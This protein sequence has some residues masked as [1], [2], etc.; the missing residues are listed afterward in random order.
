MVARN[1][2]TFTFA[3]VNLLRSVVENHLAGIDIIERIFP[4][5]VYA[6]AQ[7]VVKETKKHIVIVEYQLHGAKILFMIVCHGLYV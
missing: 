2:D 6:T 7:I 1:K 3:H 4:R 5:T